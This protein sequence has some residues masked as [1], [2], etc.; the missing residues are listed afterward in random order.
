MSLRPP[1]PGKVGGPAPM[2]APPLTK[3][4]GLRLNNKTLSVARLRMT[5]VT[6]ARSREDAH[7]VRLRDS[8]PAICAF[9]MSDCLL[10]FDSH[11]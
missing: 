3:R 6:T 5:V 1:L 10:I 9:D 8:L 11:H 7:H 4:V 2:G